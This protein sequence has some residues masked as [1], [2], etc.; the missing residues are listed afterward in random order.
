MPKLAFVS[1][2]CREEGTYL[3]IGCTGGKQVQ[4]RILYRSDSLVA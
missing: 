3:D 1:V 4:P 2:E